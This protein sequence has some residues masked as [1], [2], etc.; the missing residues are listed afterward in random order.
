[1]WGEFRHSLAKNRGQ[2]RALLV[3]SRSQQKSFL[4]LLPARR[5]LGAG[6]EEKI[7]RAQIR[8]CEENFFAGWQVPASGGGV[9]ARQSFSVGGASLVWFRSGISDKM[10]SSQTVK[11]H[12]SLSGE[13]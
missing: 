6:G 11:T 2:P 4:F 10:S 13:L 7:G 12:Q 5:S 8:K 3:Q 9:P 1:V